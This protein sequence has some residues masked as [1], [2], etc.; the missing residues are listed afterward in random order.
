MTA[1]PRHDPRPL[2][3][4]TVVIEAGRHRMPRNSLF[5]PFGAGSRLL[6]H[7]NLSRADRIVTADDKE[8]S[9]IFWYLT[10]IPRNSYE[11]I[12]LQVTV[13]RFASLKF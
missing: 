13:R 4:V 12:S 10:R 6:V 8:G 5:E 2:S 1:C 11:V 7:P 9:Y 3:R